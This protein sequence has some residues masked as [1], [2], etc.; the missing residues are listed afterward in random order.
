MSKNITS[1]RSLHNS[2]LM[3]IV[4]CSSRPLLH[5]NSCNKIKMKR[6]RMAAMFILKPV[7]QH[8]GRKLVPDDIGSDGV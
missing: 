4:P 3:I 5:A 1:D 6:K 7:K 2:C 8:K